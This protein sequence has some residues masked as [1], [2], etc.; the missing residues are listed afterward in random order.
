MRLLYFTGPIPQYR[1][2]PSLAACQLN[3][4]PFLA[5]EDYNGRPRVL[6]APMGEFDAIPLLRTLPPDLFPTAIACHFDGGRV[7]VPRNLA[8][9]RCPKVLLVGAI[10]GLERTLRAVAEYTA[11]EKFDRVVLLH[12]RQHAEL[13]RRA[14]VKNLFWF[15]A[16]TFSHPD[17]AIRRA[18]RA[19]RENRL[20]FAGQIDSSRGRRL[21]LAGA[22]AKSGLPLEL[23]ETAE[24]DALK[25]YGEST[26]VFNASRNGDLN[27]RCFEA[28][29]SGAALLTDRLA[30][31]SGLYELWEDG[32]DIVTY[33]DEAELLARARRLLDHPDEA[34]AIGRAGAAWF[35][36]RF[37]AE[38]RRADFARLVFDGR[39]APGFALPAPGAVTVNLSND[40]L[41][42]CGEVEKLHES[43]ERVRVLADPG[44]PADFDRILSA[45]PRLSVTRDESQL[46]GAPAD[47]GIAGAAAI[48]PAMASSRRL[49]L[50]NVPDSARA[51]VHR[52]F[53]GN[54]FRAP[55][56]SALYFTRGDL[57]APPPA[58]PP[59]VQRAHALLAAGDIGRAL[60][61]ARE[62]VERHPSSPEGYLT[63]AEL[64]AEARQPE[65][66]ARMLEQA[67]ALAPE[68]PRVWLLGLP[69]RQLPRT[70]ER[71]FAAAWRGWNERDHDRL[72]RFSLLALEQVP[73]RADAHRLA[74]RAA[75]VAVRSSKAWMSHGTALQRLARAAELAPDRPELWRELAWERLRSGGFLPECVPAF[76]AA[77]ALEPANALDWYGLGEAF[78]ALQ[79]ADEAEAAFAS[80]LSCS[81]GEPFLWRGLGHA[82]KRQGRIDEAQAAYRRSC[83]GEPGPGARTGERPRVVFVAQ[84]GHSW[85]CLASIHAAFAADPEWETVV[86][87][88]PWNHPSMERSSRQDDPNKIFAFLREQK[89]PHVHWQEFPLAEQAADLVFIQNPYDSTRSEGWRIPDLVRAGHRLCYV[90]YAIEFGGTFED[91]GF[92]FNLGL[93]QM[94]WAVVARSEAHRACFARHC[95]AGDRHVLVCGHPKFDGLGG[96]TEAV[97]DPALL[98]FAAGR[99][100]VLWTP[101]FDVRLNGT[102]FGDGYSTFWRW[103][104]FLLEEF[105]RRPDLAVV[106]RPHP[107]FFAALEHRG[108]MSRA[109][110]DGW[111][112]RCAAAGNVL[113]N[114]SSEYY[115]VLA[116]ADVLLSDA[117]SLMIEFGI[118][119]KPVGYLHNP[120]GPMSHYDYEL[121]FDYIRRHC[122]W[123]ENEADI[124]SFLDRAAAGDLAPSAERR[125]ELR[126][127]MGVRPG[128]AGAEVKRA[129][130]ERLGRNAAVA[131]GAGA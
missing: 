11:A 30:P 98:R 110:L 38:R 2:P 84:N 105:A 76:Q 124:R 22:L 47:L 130:E 118:S 26:V 131:A 17:E 115:S 43:E 119:G 89:I 68:D 59:E 100:L 1:N 90:P 103:R 63:I 33:G 104:D 13:F 4:G 12:D 69:S 67:R 85:P 73:H 65:L 35:Q 66:R 61:A 99:R 14:G 86:V 93:Q 109:E 101:H 111:C 70:A 88:L 6:R 113:L 114:T 125:D 91:V 60:V 45:Y 120:D 32:R 27:L 112:A 57:P 15:P 121:D 19:T 127:R 92:Q 107:T 48:S 7:S 23:R 44:A 80:G 39:P 52:V 129:I 95:A 10:H 116:A 3:C 62:A 75:L 29:A 50:W 34:A 31:D 71:L 96:E 51:D 53:A 37:S 78:L 122:V 46:A 54:G 97:P 42:V 123:A 64:A 28:L 40:F 49:W 94:A 82:L 128:G 58:V 24:S 72:T 87:A 126:R 106:V 56:G 81:P 41:T 21:R 8:Q 18:V 25:F 55:C 16:L 102:R 74:A 108:F 117:S 5:T 20:A 36:S 77:L 9:L 79:R 83:G